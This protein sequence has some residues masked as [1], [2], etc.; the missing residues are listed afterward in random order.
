[1]NTDTI[2]NIINL[3]LFI[4]II[5]LL[6]NKINYIENFLCGG[7]CTINEECNLKFKC[8]KNKCCSEE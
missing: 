4:A 5:I 2:I 1:M 3:L 7:K 6:I 8:I